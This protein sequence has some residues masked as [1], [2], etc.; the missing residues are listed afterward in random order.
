MAAWVAAGAAV[1]GGLMARQGQKETNAQN[2]QLGREQMAFQE[3][4]SNTAMQRRVADLKAAGL[5]PMLAYNDSAS[6]PAGAM[7][8]VENEEVPLGQAVANAAVIYQQ[9]KQAQANIGVADAQARKTTAEAQLIEAQV[10]HSA[11]NAYWNAQS[12]REQ[13]DKLSHEVHN[14]E[15]EERKREFDVTEYQPLVAEY[16]RLLNQAERL[17]IP[18]KEATSKFFEKVPEGKWAQIIKQ[19]LFGG[20]SILKR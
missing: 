11:S 3:R 13:F 14:L 19:L 17:G 1:V 9:Q 5:N 15:L 12:V 4:M 16:Q 6:T 18:E 20:G 7:P 2:I 10:P 8:Q